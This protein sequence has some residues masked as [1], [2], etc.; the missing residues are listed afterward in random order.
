[1]SR[2]TSRAASEIMHADSG[3]R[4]TAM[5]GTSCRVWRPQKIGCAIPPPG[6]GMTTSWELGPAPPSGVRDL[7]DTVRIWAV[8]DFM[9][10]GLGLC[11]FHWAA[12]L[13]SRLDQPM[14]PSHLFPLHATVAVAFSISVGVLDRWCI[15]HIFFL[16]FY[17]L[18][19]TD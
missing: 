15:L 13:I 4:G 10:S 1:M 17:V 6:Y 12:F 18:R 16:S 19:L 8:L 14:V 5:P 3:A 2:V 11:I 7:H 9:W